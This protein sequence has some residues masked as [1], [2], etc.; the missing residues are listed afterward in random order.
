M[1]TGETACTGVAASST[2]LYAYFNS[3]GTITNGAGS[4]NSYTA[5]RLRMGSLAGAF[6]ANTNVI[7]GRDNNSV[8]M[9]GAYGCLAYDTGNDILYFARHNTQSGLSGNPVLAFKPGDF[10]SGFQF[11]TSTTLAGPSD[12]RV[13]A[14]GGKK[15]WLVGAG[16]TATSTLW[17]WKGPSTADASKYLTLPAASGSMQIL[18]LALDGSN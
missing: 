1:S 15:D 11:A 18:G 14:H 2:A 13:I 12:L 10:S 16:N 4:G 8:T 7:V 5:A 9:L 17:I 3:G 6:S